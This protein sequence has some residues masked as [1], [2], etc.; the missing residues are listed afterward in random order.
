MG[1]H[2]LTPREEYEARCAREREKALRKYGEEGLLPGGNP[3]LDV[4]D[5]ATNEVVGLRRYAEIIFNRRSEWPPEFSYR[6]AALARKIEEFSQMMGIELIALR[7]GLV[8]RGVDM[9]RAE[10]DGQ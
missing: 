9:G 8:G 3:E 2:R 4:L 5:Y 7:Q 1:E 10:N 6:T